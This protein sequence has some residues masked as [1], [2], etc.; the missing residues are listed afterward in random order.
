MIDALRQSV[1]NMPNATWIRDRNVDNY[2]FLGAFRVDRAGATQVEYNAASG[3]MN[4]VADEDS[5]RLKLAGIPFFRTTES[6]D[7]AANVEEAT[8][9][10][11]DL[12]IQGLRLFGLCGDDSAI[13]CRELAENSYDSI[14]RYAALD[15]NRQRATVTAFLQQSNCSDHIGRGEDGQLIDGFQDNFEPMETPFC[16][17]KNV[18][19][20]G[21]AEVYFQRPDCYDSGNVTCPRDGNGFSRI[22]NAGTV[23]TPNLYNPF[24]HA[25]LVANGR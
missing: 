18:Y 2:S 23:E 16:G 10:V 19:A 15:P 8:A 14:Q 17:D 4:W 12:A 3:N 9:M 6:G 5:F 13:D 24:W 21:Q 25:R 7:A 20:I 1:S 22:D 11:D